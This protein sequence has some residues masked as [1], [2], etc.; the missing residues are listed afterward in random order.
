M[1][2]CRAI[3]DYEARASDC[4]EIGKRAQY[5]PEGGFAGQ[6]C[7]GAAEGLPNHALA[8]ELGSN[9]IRVNAIAPAMIR[10]ELSQQLPQSFLDALAERYPL[11]RLGEVSD[12]SATALFLAGEQGQF[13]TGQTLCPAGGDVMV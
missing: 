12:V 7:L 1:E 10:T 4:A 5:C 11:G 6:D 3:G 9:N 8:K 2:K 13:F